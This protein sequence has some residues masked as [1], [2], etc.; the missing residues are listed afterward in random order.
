[1]E[2]HLS[3]HL[4]LKSIKDKR[5]IKI[6]KK[7]AGA[8]N[9]TIKNE[10]EKAGIVSNIIIPL[11]DN[12]NFL[13][14]A[15]F[16][17]DDGNNLPNM[18]A[19]RTF[20]YY[21]EESLRNDIQSKED[22]KQTIQ[23]LKSVSNYRDNETGAHLERMSRFARIIAQKI[24]SEYS[25]SNDFIENI[26]AYSPLHDV[27]KISIPDRILFK[28]GKLTEAEF[29]EMQMHPVLGEN[30]LRDVYQ[31]KTNKYPMEE[32]K[33]ICNIIRYH[34]ERIDGTGYPDQ[35]RGNNIPLEA[36]ITTVADVFDALTSER[37]YKQAWPIEKTLDYL[38][39]NSATMFDAKMVQTLIDNIDL[40]LDV[41][42]HFQDEEI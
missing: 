18:N 30:I 40:I 12:S 39:K 11:E 35:L 38:K 36:R 9:K 3:K 13:G 4:T 14:F 32:F 37:P 20:K 16:D 21:I 1:M 17:F 34:H 24:S 10:L 26:Y 25:L 7:I 2:S 31:A 42:S 6:N 19:L 22:L 15:F 41:K 28:N 33:L 5:C 27:G 23:A 29:A 8:K